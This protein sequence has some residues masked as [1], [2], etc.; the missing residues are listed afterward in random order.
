MNFE[1][2]LKECTSL[3]MKTQYSYLHIFHYPE[4]Y[5]SK[6]RNTVMNLRKRHYKFTKKVDE[7]D[8]KE[9][10]L[11][12]EYLMDCTLLSYISIQKYNSQYR[13][14]KTPFGNGL[15]N[16]LLAYKVC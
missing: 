12:E 13:E 15:K 14:N 5:N 3:K 1:Q 7:K 8:P 16:H 9:E 4:N 11:F 10:F 2:Y 6:T